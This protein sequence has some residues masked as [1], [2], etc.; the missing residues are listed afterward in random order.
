MRIS[1][2]YNN[3]SFMNL[4]TNGHRV[5]CM[6]VVEC[7]GISRNFLDFAKLYLQ[8][9]S[10]HKKGVSTLIIFY[11]MTSLFQYIQSSSQVI[12]QFRS[13][14]FYYQTKWLV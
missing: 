9:E 7:R 8:C 2:G 1:I 10:Q 6:E 4:P 5:A 13:E 14:T 3:D 12:F 11:P